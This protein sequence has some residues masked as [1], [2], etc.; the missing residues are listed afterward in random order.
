LKNVGML[1]L[2]KFTP[3][4]NR[5]L[6]AQNRLRIIISSNHTST[7]N[8]ISKYT[9]RTL[10]LSAMTLAGLAGTANAQ[11]FNIDFND[12]ISMSPTCAPT[13]AAAGT[14]GTWN[15]VD[16]GL[17]TP[18]NLLNKAGI[19]TGVSMTLA[20]TLTFTL[21][22]TNA[23]Y[24]GEDAKMM[25]DVCYGTGLETI[26]FSGLAIGNYSIYTYALAPDNKSGL[27]TGIDC[28]QSLDG[29]QQAGGA[30]W[31]G[32]HVEGGSYSKHSAYVSDG[33]L[34]LDITAILGFESINGIQIEVEP[35][36]PGAAFCF[37]DGTGNA[38]PCSQNGNVG[39]GCANSSGTGGALLVGLGNPSLANDSFQIQITGVPGD[40]PGL[41][42]RTANQMNGGLG[43]PVGDGLICASGQSHRSHVQVTSAGSTTFTDFDGTAFGTE[44]IGVGIPT[45]YQFWYRD[46]DNTCNSS[47]N[48]SN[49]WATTWTL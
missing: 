19:A 6:S 25:E 10:S 12:G 37:G 11:G 26:D 39:E 42:L 13:Y 44:T 14:A 3:V 45:N 1:Y 15:G 32:S 7:M 33:T 21:Q 23:A 8:P 2:R 36:N 20:S 40:K 41:I 31:T 48:F 5:L 30:L 34:H 38:C 27:I 28:D 17:A 29:L 49:A 46:T 43:N 22:F 4:V 9:V 16:A 47:F 18:T 24:T 35:P